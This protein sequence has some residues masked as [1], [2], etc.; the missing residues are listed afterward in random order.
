MILTDK[1]IRE[2]CLDKKN[3]KD[4]GG[5][6]EPFSEDALQSESY[7]L[8][9]G[10][11]IEVLKKDVRCLSLLEQES[12]DSMY[13]EIDL[14]VSGY[15]ISPKEYIL[16]SLKEKVSL[17]DNITA[18]IRPRTR[19]TRLGL[20]VSD[21]HCNSTYSGKLRIGIFNA[22]D[23]P[24]KIFPGIRIAQMVFEELKSK[25]SE[26]K[27][28]KN[29]KNAVYQGEEKFVGAKFSDELEKKVSETVDL[30]LKK[31]D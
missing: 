3:R 20:I 2:L 1:E 6:I 21:Q 12:I 18:H 25:P 26:E 30:L 31:D 19:F 16:V 13:E 7:D 15:I 14:A 27:M 28:Y 22:T 8:A 9:I 11:E 5:L 24:I 23:Y 17:P 10:T 4:R 29:K